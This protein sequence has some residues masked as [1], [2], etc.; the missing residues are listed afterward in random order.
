MKDRNF[1]HRLVL[2]LAT[3]EAIERGLVAHDAPEV[4]FE[5]RD[6]GVRFEMTIDGDIPALVE[7]NNWYRDECRI[8]VWLW[9]SEGGGLQ[10]GDVECSG[11]LNRWMLPG[12]L[13]IE[14]FSPPGFYVAA[15]RANRLARL[16][17]IDPLKDR[18]G[19]M[20]LYM[21]TIETLETNLSRFASAVVSSDYNRKWS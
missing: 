15:R 19:L 13:S 4:E 16:P 18:F 9:P 6:N 11:W 17:G 2:T 14:Q 5:M 7:I 3:Y 8:R 20:A 21:R 12:R 1:T 10:T